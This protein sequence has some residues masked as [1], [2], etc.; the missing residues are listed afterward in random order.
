MCDHPRCAHL[1]HP[2]GARHPLSRRALLGAGA[3][4]ALAAGLAGGFA[5]GGVAPAFAQ[6]AA[7]RPNAI[8]PDE[9]LKRLVDGNARYAGGTMQNR[10]FSAGR[11]ARASAQYPIAGLVS[12][13]D[14]RVAPEYAFDQGPG[15]L[16]VVRLA[17]N[18]VDDHGLASLEYGVAVLGMPLIMVLGHSNCGAVA[19]T[20]KAVK[21]KTELPGHLP[22]LI[23]AIKPA[24][25][26]AEKTKAANPLDAAIAENV[27]YNVR[28][29]V[30]A[31]PIVAKAVADG[32]VKIVGGVYD[33]ATGKVAMV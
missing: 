30:E 7:A 31:K 18:F 21:E 28:R 11:V 25:E 10:D 14:S 20:L 26:T 13:A 12:C 16:F 24:I 4:T 5:A 15:E 17:G 2:A 27:R 32:K 33:I 8:G 23:E 6:D 19:A 9:A 1:D 29:L 22:L 3:A